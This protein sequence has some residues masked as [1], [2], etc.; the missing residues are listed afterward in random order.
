[1][2]NIPSTFLEV[3]V[4]SDQCHP[5]VHFSYNK[6]RGTASYMFL[7]KPQ[8][9]PQ[10]STMAQATSD[11]TSARTHNEEDALAAS[12]YIRCLNN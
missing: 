5:Y 1:M 10:V 4:S 6:N 11:V 12:C 2:H 7:T 3:D 8:D 9:E